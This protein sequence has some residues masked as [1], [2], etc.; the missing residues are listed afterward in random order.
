MPG[1]DWKTVSIP[2]Q[3]KRLIEAYLDEADCPYGSEGEVVVAAVVQWLAD[4]KRKTPRLKRHGKWVD[5][6]DF[7]RR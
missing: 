6:D 4:P 2:P 1:G 3:A 7:R 5:L